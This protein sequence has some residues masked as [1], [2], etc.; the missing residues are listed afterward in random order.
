MRGFL[1]SERRQGILPCS[2]KRKRVI[3]HEACYETGQ[4]ELDI[5]KWL[6]RAVQKKFQ[7]SEK[8]ACHP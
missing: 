2:H 6:Y 8:K 4:N 7:K 5:D 1:S 3:Q